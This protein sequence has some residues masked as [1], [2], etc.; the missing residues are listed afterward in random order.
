[1]KERY[2][3]RGDRA[4]RGAVDLLSVPYTRRRLNLP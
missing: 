1:M 3:R 4:K 2:D